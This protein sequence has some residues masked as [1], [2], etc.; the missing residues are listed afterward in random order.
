MGLVVKIWV[1]RLKLVTRIGLVAKNVDFFGS[2]WWREP[3][4][5]FLSVNLSQRADLETTFSIFIARFVAES[6]SRNHIFLFYRKICR[7]ERFSRPPFTF[8]SV[9]LS[10]RAVLVTTFTIFID[11]FVAESGS[12]D[13]L[14]LFYR[15][16]CRRESF[17]KPPFT[18]LSVNLSQRADLETTFSIF[19]A[20]F[21][22]ES[23]SRNHIFHFYR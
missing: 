21:V 13:H 2:K 22:A 9:N 12:R 7:R 10:Q 8:L 3:P 18:F 15:W 4:F 17:S 11:E 6:W 16:I 19:I 14:F 23:W 1:F 5:T 20:R